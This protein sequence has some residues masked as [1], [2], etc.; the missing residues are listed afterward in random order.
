MDG[1][2]ESLGKDSQGENHT[3]WRSSGEMEVPIDLAIKLEKERPQRFMMVDRK[4]AKELL[5]DLVEDI[6]EEPEAIEPPKPEEV[7]T[8]L[9]LNNMTKDELND[10]AAKRDYKVNPTKQKKPQMV[11]SLAKQIKKRTGKKVE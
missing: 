6:E 7:V 8:L 9:Q 2:G 10:W 11:R 1:E 3:F 5:G 4:M